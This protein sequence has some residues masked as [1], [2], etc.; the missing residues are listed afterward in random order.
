MPTSK[1]STCD[2]CNHSLSR[3]NL[4]NLILTSIMMIILFHFP[5]AFY[6]SMMNWPFS[7]HHQTRRYTIRSAEEPTCCIATPI[8]TQMRASVR[9]GL[10]SWRYHTY[11]DKHFVFWELPIIRHYNF[12]YSMARYKMKLPRDD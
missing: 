6:P 8:T 9:A 1:I 11:W 3:C 5:R 4:S 10:I 7:H 12:V 2:L